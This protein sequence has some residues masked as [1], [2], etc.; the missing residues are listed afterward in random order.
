MKPERATTTDRHT[1]RVNAIT[2]S[3]DGTTMATVSHDKTAKLW[4]VATGRVRATFAGHTD[5]VL[6][7][8]FTPDG[9][10]LLTG[11]SDMTVK[12]WDASAD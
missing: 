1:G 4:D 9:K 8:K 6:A 3:P 10:T 5:G 12:W 2:F 11:S 7:V